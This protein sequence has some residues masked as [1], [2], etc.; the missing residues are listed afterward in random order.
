M[1]KS[2]KD[3]KIGLALSGG[4]IRAIMFHTGMLEYLAK[5]GL[6]EC[7]KIISTVSGGSI[8]TGLIIS[9]NGGKWP[10]SSEYLE[11]VFPRIKDIVCNISISKCWYEHL[12]NP[13]YWNYLTDRDKVLSIAL[14]KQWKI[15]GKLSDIPDNPKW[16]MTATTAKNGGQWIFCKNYMG[17]EE[18]GFVKNPDISL[19]G[20]IAA[21]A[22]YPGI[23]GPYQ[24]NTKN[25]TWLKHVPEEDNKN[26]ETIN[27]DALTY[28][29][30]DGGLY[31]NLGCE[32]LFKKFGE[33][34]IDEIDSVIIS[35]ACAPLNTQWYTK[36]NILTRTKK[37]VDMILTHVD[38]LRLRWIRSYFEK[39][40]KLGILVKIDKHYSELVPENK[41]HLFKNHFFM[42]KESVDI[43][44]GIKTHLNKVS[45]QEYE[46]TVRNGY[47]TALIKCRL[48]FDYYRNRNK[49]HI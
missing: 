45:S 49:I 31:D 46:S 13:F 21:S 15:T 33:R 25:Y 43:V 29:C 10:T 2:I 40:I 4:G 28:Y 20:A 41:K 14:E 1:K 35:D 24:L 9:L 39:N 34:L 48:Y 22:A 30:Y 7:I 47:E 19:S 26:N 11:K 6:L 38:E 36:W 23:I 18:I 8:F 42:P 5:L 16:F 3:F 27:P 32:S 12:I 44:K 37:M 17:N